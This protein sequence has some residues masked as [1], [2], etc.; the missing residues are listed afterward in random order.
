MYSFCGESEFVNNLGRIIIPEENRFY[1]RTEIPINIPTDI[2][3][4]EDIQNYIKNPKN[5]KDIMKFH[6]VDAC[7]KED[8]TFGQQVERGAISIFT[9]KISENS[10]SLPPSDR[11]HV[12]TAIMGLL[13]GN[14]ETVNGDKVLLTDKLVTLIAIPNLI[15]FGG[16]A[17]LETVGER[18]GPLSQFVGAF[19]LANISDELFMDDFQKASIKLCGVAIE[20]LKKIASILID[21]LE[22]LGN[23]VASVAVEIGKAFLKFVNDVKIAWNKAMNFVA[24]LYNDI[25]AAGK[26]A[27]VAIDN[28][29]KKVAN[30]I[31]NFFKNLANSLKKLYNLTKNAIANTWNKAVNGINTVF[32]TAKAEI[33]KQYQNFKGGV[34]YLINYSKKTISNYGNKGVNILKNFSKKVI[35]GM[36]SYKS[37]QLSVDLVRLQDIQIK[38][39]SMERRFGEVIQRIVNDTNKVS[40]NVSSRYSEYYVKQQVQSVNRVCDQIKDSGRRLS[41]ALLKKESALKYALE[42]YKDVEKMLCSNI[43]N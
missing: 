8:G 33:K 27:I 2:N 19:V 39:R 6:F 21:K 10:L 40:S 1:F 37:T 31:S 5:L 16:D 24:G 34:N 3:G 22:K 9:Q 35:R 25:V 18:A 30:V 43:R 13:Q 11:Y 17:L 42:H 20:N 36:G 26:A 32:N 12:Y 23:W 38:I 4:I 41:N 29:R 7:L 28:F 14:N 15:D